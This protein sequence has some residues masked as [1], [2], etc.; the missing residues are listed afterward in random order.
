[1]LKNVLSPRLVKKV[2]MQGGARNEARGVLACYAAAPRERANAADGPFS[3]ACYA[4]TEQ[5]V[6][7]LSSVLRSRRAIR[8][9]IAIMRAFVRLREALSVHKEL[10]ARLA[11]LERRIAGH[12]ES[13]RTLFDAIRQ[14]MARPEKARRP[15]GFRVEETRP[16]YRVRRLR[17]AWR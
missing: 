2:Q 14:L 11:D 9:N 3:A 17:R 10:A 4:F 7:M 15:V 16:A 5:G 8:V 6:A 12:D 1:M 13:V